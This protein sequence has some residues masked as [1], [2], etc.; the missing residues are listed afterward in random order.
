VSI[1]ERR[2]RGSRA[3]HRV[4][5]P[6]CEFLFQGVLPILGNIYAVVYLSY[7]GFEK[8]IRKHDKPLNLTG[9]GGK[10]GKQRGVGL[11]GKGG[12]NLLQIGDGK[13]VGKYK[14]E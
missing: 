8:N 11:K 10:V 2:H 12:V 5:Q 3:L 9:G 4:L 1:T 6:A 7:N 13:T 14:N